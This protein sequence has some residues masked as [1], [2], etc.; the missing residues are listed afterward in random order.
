[1]ARSLLKRALGRGGKD[2]DDNPDTRGPRGLLMRAAA[3]V[4]GVVYPTNASGN[5]MSVR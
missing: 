3:K 2:R 5:S 4:A 1:V